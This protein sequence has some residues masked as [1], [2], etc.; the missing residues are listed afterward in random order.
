MEDK[1]LMQTT[2]IS[3]ETLDKALC[4]LDDL[5]DEIDERQEE[6]GKYFNPELDRN[7]EKMICSVNEC[8]VGLGEVVVE[9]LAEYLYEVDSYSC[10][11]A[12]DVLGTIGS[13]TAVPALIDA[14][15]TDADDLC[16]DASN[17]LV[18]I[19]APAIQSLIVG[20]TSVRTTRRSATTSVKP[21]RY[22]RSAH[23][24]GY[25]IHGRSPSW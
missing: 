12:A 21:A 24:H 13:S 20:S 23:S 17:A 19:G 25:R 2:E 16:D 7:L 14:I 22:I 6:L 4:A 18:K 8:L 9:P 3:D 1:E 5:C 11:I 15:E 10:I